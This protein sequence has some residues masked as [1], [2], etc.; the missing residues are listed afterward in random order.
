MGVVDKRTIEKYQQE[1]KEKG[2]DSWWLAYVMDVSDDEK[3]KGKTVE[4]G[5]AHFETETKRYT[6]F[7]APGHKNYV[8]DMIMGAACADIGGLVIS[9]RRGEFEAGFEREGQT[10][11]HAQLA[12]SLGIQKL[13]II[14]NKMDE[15]NWAKSRF[16]EIKEGITPFLKECGYDIEKDIVFVPI[17][18]LRGDNIIKE[19]NQCDWWKGGTLVEILNNIELINRNPEGLARIPVLDKM[20]DRGPIIFG[21]CESGTIRMGDKLTVM[22][23]NIPVQIVNI[24]NG[25]DE[26]VA[27]ALPGE[28]VKIKLFGIDDEEV[29]NRGD[30]LCPR[31]NLMPA[32]ELLECELQILELL[33]F[34]PVLS[35]GYQCIIHLHTIAEE[36]TVKDIMMSWETNDKGEVTEKKAP[37]FTR[38]GA[39]IICRITTR[40]PVAMEKYDVIPQLGR[41]TLRDQGKTIAIGKILKYKP[42]KVL[43]WQIQ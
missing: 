35:K 12:I 30:V 23:S 15:C 5:R 10:R 6:I 40:I 2:R 29:I 17:S 13:V 41:F 28:N 31:D 32:T 25:K 20:R 1:A 19:T 38:S 18:G 42:A 24:Y 11:E 36:C 22:P 37:K 7:D 21:K 9:A 8:P 3:A 27:Y 33:E 34:K 4:V 16:D 43:D 26:A 14:V 39:K